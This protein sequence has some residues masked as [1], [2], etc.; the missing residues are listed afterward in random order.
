MTLI[1]FQKL[2][3][4]SRTALIVVCVLLFLFSAM[5][6]KITQRVTG[7][8]T[9]FFNIISR[10]ARLPENAFRDVLF[11]GP[12]KVSQAVLGG[13][14]V[15]FQEPD[16][17]LAVGLMHPI[18]IILCSVWAVGRAAGAVAG[19]VDKGTM[20]LL[21]SQPVPRSRLILAH[22]M[23]DAVAIPLL[24]LSLHA[25]TRAGLWL[26]G[27][28]KPDYT[29]V[30]EFL[31]KN[32]SPGMVALIPT[33]DRT[34]TPDVS[35]QPLALVNTAALMFA[36]SGLTMALSAAG[37]SRWK[38][39]GYGVLAGVLMFAANV[40]GQLWDAAG[41]VRPFSAYFYYQPQKIMLRGGDWTADPFG[42]A[43]VP[44][45]PVLLAAGALGYAL[46]LWVF[47]RRDLPA[48]L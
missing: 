27:D 20:E 30:R 6:V 7:E 33:D 16:D 4:D 9:P 48:P 11:R 3:R 29:A 32:G 14:D 2:L 28:F 37:R 15:Q 12:G 45:V 38:V 22:L 47:T 19:E 36:L 1:L 43:G 23:V 17:F 26:V 41:W 44:V 34:I 46:A 13:G 8:I 25:G 39:V 40:L 24:C 21:M 5:W 42:V 35:R 18:V 10:V 31:E